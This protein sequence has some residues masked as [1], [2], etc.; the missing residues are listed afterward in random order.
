MKRLVISIVL[1]LF[2]TL[3]SAQQTTTIYGNYK[4]GSDNNRTELKI[5]WFDTET[6]TLNKENLRGR[7]QGNGDF[8]FQTDKIVH[9]YTQCWL[10][11]GYKRTQLLLSPG[12]SIYMRANRPIFNESI[13]FHGIGAGINNFRRD[14]KLNFAKRKSEI[15]KYLIPL[16][17]QNA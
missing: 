12:D 11:L 14:I 10:H 16:V 3:V 2:V 5:I 6:L 9:P 7:I 4:N 15:N 1:L 13:E 17:S 8:S